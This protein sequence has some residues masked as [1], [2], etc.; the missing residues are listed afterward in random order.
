MSRIAVHHKGWTG[1]DLSWLHRS[2]YT[3]PYH[4]TSAGITSPNPGGDTEGDISCHAITFPG[5]W[6]PP[7]MSW[8]L[9]P[10]SRAMSRITVHHR[11]WT[12]VELS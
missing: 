3:K 8:T 7:S 9:P 12:R 11:G 4:L 6:G 1:Q 10:H 5:F 2:I